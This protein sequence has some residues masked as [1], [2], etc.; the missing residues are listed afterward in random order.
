MGVFTYQNDNASTVATSRL[1]KALVV[2]FDNLVPKIMEGV[3]IEI[4]EGNGGPGTLKK[5]TYPRGEETKYLVQK[6]EAV[7]EASYAY[8]YSMI[9]GSGL[10][11]G[12]EKMTFETKLVEGA[13]GG[14][15]GKVSITYF[16]KTDAPPSDEELANGKASGDG[17]F[18]AV[19]AYLLAHP[20]HYN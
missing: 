4:L 12:V 6:V 11:E 19:E 16:T 10:A 1:Y 14:S 8:N 15:V 9:E 5:L 2:D 20:D 17:L 3:T 18:R 7:D 13:D